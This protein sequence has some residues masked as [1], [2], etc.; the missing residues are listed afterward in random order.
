MLKKPLLL[1]TISGLLAG[2]VSLV[3]S[4]LYVK[5]LAVDY[6]SLV[7][8]T[9]IIIS[10]LLGGLVAAVGYWVLQRVFKART[11]VFFNLLF[12]ILSF[13]SIVGAFWTKLPLD[14]DRPELFP[15]LMLPMH[16][17]PVLAWLTLKPIFKI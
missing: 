13:A 11:E 14:V 5:L 4:N 9:K 6:S 12:T 10:S 3:Y 17:F 7:T 1:G 16:L 2:V 15:W 8:P